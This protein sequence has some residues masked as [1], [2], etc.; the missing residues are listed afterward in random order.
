MVTTRI[1]AIPEDVGGRFSVWS[2]ASFAA[3]LAIGEH[4]YA[5]FVAGGRDG[6]SAIHHKWE[7]G[8]D[9]W[10][11]CRFIVLHGPDA[12]PDPRDLPPVHQLVAADGHVATEDIRLRVFQGGRPKPDVTDDVAEYIR[13][14]RLFTGLTVPRETRVRLE[15]V[16][17]K[18]VTADKSEKAL[19]LAVVKAGMA[20]IE[21]LVRREL[22]SW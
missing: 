5:E 21:A 14:Y 3:Q 7:L 19:R 20:M 15:G 22:D 9:A 8:E 1:L 4:A 13:R 18:I 2:A 16:R 17:L 11:N 6:A 12:P 10:K